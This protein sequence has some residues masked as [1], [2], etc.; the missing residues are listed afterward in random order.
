[1]GMLSRLTNWVRTSR[2]RHA[3]VQAPEP[4]AAQ[5]ALRDAIGPRGPSTWF[6]RQAAWNVYDIATEG[7]ER[8]ED[9]FEDDPK[10]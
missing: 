2:R 3:Q 5:K 7:A 8:Y 1:M 6:G 4:N 9:S 10:G